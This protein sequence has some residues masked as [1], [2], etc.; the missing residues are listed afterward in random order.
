[1]ISLKKTVESLDSL[2]RLCSA[3][4]K[5]YSSALDSV[6]RHVVPA[7][8]SM[9]EQFRTAI[10][11]LRR[12]VQDEPS[13]ATITRTA[14]EL[15]RELKSFRD[16][17]SDYFH[18]RERDIR[19][20]LELLRDAAATVQEKS[21][22]HTDR[23]LK[24]AQRLDNVSRMEDLGEIRRR[25]ASDVH[26]LREYVN[27]MSAQGEATAADLREQLHTF[28][29]RLQEAEGQAATD[30]LTGLANRREGD[31]QIDD[32]IHANRDFCILLYD[33][34]RFKQINDRH[35]HQAGDEVLRLFARRLLPQIR[36]GDTAVRWGGDEF[37]V[38]VDCD[39]RNAIMR[40]KEIAKRACGTYS[41]NVCGSV[42]HLEVSASAGVAERRRGESKAGLF[43]RA[44]AALYADKAV[45][46]AG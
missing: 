1:M 41:I 7:G 39:L 2:E 6:A 42:L 38:V 14:E 19:G 11:G 5:S 28:Q 43:R 3:V 26:A 15:D 37:L 36:V 33:L 30:E 24:F 16:K 29:R 40:A 22:V 8:Q 18:R 25:L 17:A 4:V 13:E 27:Q 44:D 10:T 23:F 12:R 32:K 9:P 31:R 21:E 20:I 45:A 34:D 35:G 46:R